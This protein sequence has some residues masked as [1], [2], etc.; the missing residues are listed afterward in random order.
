MLT[1]HNKRE[2]WLSFCLRS[3]L[4]SKEVS[5]PYRSETTGVLKKKSIFDL[6]HL[7]CIIRSVLQIISQWVLSYNLKQIRSQCLSAIFTSSTGYIHLHPFNL[8]EVV[9]A[10]GGGR[11]Y[12]SA[13]DTN[14]RKKTFL[15]EASTTV[16]IPTQWYCTSSSHSRLEHSE[17]FEH[18]VGLGNTDLHLTI[19]GVRGDCPF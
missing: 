13:T 9:G 10:C 19:G 11:S 8:E 17:H 4:Q 1:L 3:P 7:I 14:K 15:E 12:A 5:Q 16:F 2:Y 18:L 6:S